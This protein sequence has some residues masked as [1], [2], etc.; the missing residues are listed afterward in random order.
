MRDLLLDRNFSDSRRKRK[1]DEV[2]AVSR[3]RI[4]AFKK[5]R[6]S[7]R[8]SPSSL[9]P[10]GKDGE[11]K[12]ASSES[13]VRSRMRIGNTSR[14]NVCRRT[15]GE[16]SRNAC[17]PMSAAEARG[18]RYALRIRDGGLIPRRILSAGIASIPGGLSAMLPGG[19]GGGGAH[20]NYASA[21]VLPASGFGTLDPSSAVGGSRIRSRERPVRAMRRNPGDGPMARDAIAGKG[22]GK[23]RRLASIDCRRSGRESG[24]SRR[25]PFRGHAN[26]RISTVVLARRTDG[27]GFLFHALYFRLPNVRRRDLIRSISV[28]SARAPH[29][30]RKRTRTV[31]GIR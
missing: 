19:A 15:N 6:S 16:I 28:G 23:T 26:F 30:M 8:S 3:F 7:F 13:Q 22:A 18:E 29:V 27:T 12:L 17:V 25:L 11:S 24:K 2:R 9:L 10:G 1:P 4:C 5:D 20:S 31:R 14:A 21:I